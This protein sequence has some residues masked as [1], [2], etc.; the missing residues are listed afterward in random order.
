MV[1]RIG[2][3]GGI[4]SG[5]T[6]IAEVLEAMSY[7]VYYSD[8]RS[9]DLCNHHPG[10]KSQ[11]IS[12]FGDN[13]YDKNELNREFLAEQIFSQ[14]ELR[15]KVNEIIH[16]IVRE[17]FTS[18]SLQQSSTLLFNEAAILFETGAYKQFDATVLVCAPLHKRIERIMLR[19][20]IDKESVLQ[21][22]NSQWTDEQ[23]RRLTP[24]C[25]ENDGVQ[26]VLIQIESML[27][28]LQH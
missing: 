10:I 14:P 21:R 6:M 18:W 17:D 9:K 26:P 5:K 23:K 12:L 20:L 11:L 27:N 1:K 28:S 3:T 15:L 24:Y 4:G 7:P 22:I 25:I 19:D 8:T 2:L 13:A 16:P